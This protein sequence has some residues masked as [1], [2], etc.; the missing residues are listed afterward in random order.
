MDGNEVDLRLIAGRVGGQADLVDVR[1]TRL[2]AEL[3]SPPS[4][5]GRLSYDLD[6]D[7]RYG[8]EEGVFFVEAEYRLS[9]FQ[10]AAEEV[11]PQPREPFAIVEFN[12]Y[13]VYDLPERD[14]GPYGDEELEAFTQTTARFALYPFARELVYDLTRRL[15]IPPLT[16]GTMRLPVANPTGQLADE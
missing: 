2:L 4:K 7:L 5:G 13:A 6:S 8:N 3:S 15:G 9:A 10:A 1:T 12:L 14:D 16:L 11:E